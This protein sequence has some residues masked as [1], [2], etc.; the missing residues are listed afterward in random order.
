[1][2]N[3][4]DLNKVKD[5][6]NIFSNMDVVASDCSFV[7]QHPIY[8]YPVVAVGFSDYD[9]GVQI[10]NILESEENLN[11]A[12]QATRE[13]IAKAEDIFSVY[14]VIRKSYRMTFLKYIHSYLSLEDFS[15]LLNYAWISSENPNTDVNVNIRTVLSWFK[16]ADKKQLM[17]EEDYEV[18][19]NL[20]EYVTLYRG[21]GI[22]SK[23]KG[24]S[25]T[26]DI[27]IAKWFANRFQ[28]NGYILT[29]KVHKSK[30]LAYFSDRNES[31]YIVDVY[32]IDVER[33]EVE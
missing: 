28:S 31:E 23:R 15:K 9:N 21:V 25:W 8:E 24:L 22:K 20:P 10:V 6:A 33:L 19:N 30:I 5:M 13:T 12:R 26:D 32:S 7:V 18:Y 27:E 29:A 11:K 4:T 3:Q 1:M 14:F 2:R 16:K 17:N